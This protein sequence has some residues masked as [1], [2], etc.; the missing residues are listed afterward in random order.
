MNLVFPRL[1]AIMDA[2]LLPSSALDVAEQL[3]DA[4]VGIIQYRDKKISP[5]SLLDLSKQLVSL[6]RPRGVRFVVNDRPDVAALSEA[7]AVHV[8]QKDSP[9]EDARRI[10]GPDMWIGVST[11][12]LE[13]VR[14]ASQTSADY[15]AL[16]PV[17]A[18]S[19]K[20]D[21]NSVVGL[22]LIRDAR[23]LTSKPLV[24]IGGITLATVESVFRAGAD[25]VAVARDILAA[26]DPGA[27]ARRYLASAAK[28]HQ[29]AL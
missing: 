27:Q 7:G 11:H 29:E 22:Q 14:E 24:A 2:V 20:E 15:I 13:Q 16:G 3:A 1:Y 19:T 23:R 4:G 21:A 25:S 17:F 9:V 26:S 5:R 12:S 8:G 6:L 28:F 18:T 10:C